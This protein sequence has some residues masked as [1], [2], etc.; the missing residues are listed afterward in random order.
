MAAL[1]ARITTTSEITVGS[2]A[3]MFGPVMTSVGRPS[4]GRPPGTVPSIVTPSRR[5]VE[6]VAR[7]DRADDGDQRARGSSC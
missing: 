5:E 4:V 1:W 2:S 3:T 6:D 7:G